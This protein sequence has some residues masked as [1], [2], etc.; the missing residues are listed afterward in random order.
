[1]YDNGFD[2][3]EKVFCLDG[4]RDWVEVLETWVCEG[5]ENVS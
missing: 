1:M 5:M 3:I 4:Q 2:S